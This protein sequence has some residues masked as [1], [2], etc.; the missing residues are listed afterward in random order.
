MRIFN[1]LEGEL[2]DEDRQDGWRQRSA[3]VGEAIGAARIGGSVYELGEGQ[4]NFPYHYHHGV[5]EWL[6]VIAGRPTLRTP[7]GERTLEAG[8]TACFPSGR[9]GAHSL[10][11]PGRVLLLSANSPVSVVAYPD[12]DKLGTRPSDGGDRLNFRRSDAVGYW[13]GEL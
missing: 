7:D 3:R 5:E 8:D 10:R 6:V 4:Q 11:G 12:S 2:A 1:L 9:P 13:D